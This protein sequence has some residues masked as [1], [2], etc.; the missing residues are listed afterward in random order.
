MLFASASGLD[1]EISSE[2]AKMQ[3]NRIAK[4]RSFSEEQ[5][6]QL[7]ALVA[8]LTETPQYGI[9]GCSRVNVLMLNLELGKMK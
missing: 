7:N 3:I 9:F 6:N 5:K 4:A 8:Q 2:A 1:P